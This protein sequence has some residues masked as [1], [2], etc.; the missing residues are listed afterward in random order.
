MKEGVTGFI[1]LDWRRSILSPKN[2]NVNLPWV[3]VPSAFIFRPPTP[4]PHLCPRHPVLGL[5][6][7]A[8]KKES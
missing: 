8:L 1:P 4:I 3:W 6:P 5:A 7:M 2:L